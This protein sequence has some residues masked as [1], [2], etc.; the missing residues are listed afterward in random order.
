VPTDILARAHQDFAAF[1]LDD[2]ATKAVIDKAWRQYGQLIDPHS[3]V[4]LGAAW[5]AEETGLVTADTVLVSLACAHP[6]KFPDA[7]QTASGQQPQLPD[8]L[9]DLMDREEASQRC[10]NDK[11]ALITLIEQEC[12]K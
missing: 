11:A 7:V 8:H 9:A 1:C 5:Q 2:A 6:A 10:A 4:G 12:R 3:A